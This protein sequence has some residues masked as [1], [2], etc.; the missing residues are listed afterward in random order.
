ML[1]GFMIKCEMKLQPEE[2]E[3][4][5]ASPQEELEQGGRY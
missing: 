5:L 1:G 3:D 4:G 2:L